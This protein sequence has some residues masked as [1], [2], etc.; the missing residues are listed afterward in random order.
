MTREEYT[1]L[2][3]E[4]YFNYMGMLAAEVRALLFKAAIASRLRICTNF[5]NLDQGNWLSRDLS[6]FLSF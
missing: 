1:N 5:I 4:D 6:A 2:D 3:V